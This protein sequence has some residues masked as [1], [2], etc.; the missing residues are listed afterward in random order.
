MTLSVIMCPAAGRT[1]F[2]DCYRTL[3]S[4]GLYNTNPPSGL[5]TVIKY[6]VKEQVNS[7]VSLDDYIIMILKY[8]IH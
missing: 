7:Q 6:I 5:Y 2:R 4:L 3:S 1:E 8:P